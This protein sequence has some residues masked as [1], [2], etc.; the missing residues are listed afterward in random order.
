MC[1]ITYNNS[2]C[3]HGFG[4]NSA[5]T[6]TRATSD[7]HAW[8]NRGSTANHYIISNNYRRE[9]FA[10]RVLIIQQ[11]RVWSNKNPIPNEARITDADM[12]LNVA[13]SPDFHVF[14]NVNEGSNLCAFPNLGGRMNVGGGIN[15]HILA[16]RQ[17]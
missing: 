8:K 6:N 15:S 1:R 5:S 13:V 9:G 10:W 12:T 14:A 3:R 4:D 2:A 17:G 7:D 16:R 11:A